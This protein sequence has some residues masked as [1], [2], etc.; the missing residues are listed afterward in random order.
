MASVRQGSQET[1]VPVPVQAGSAAALAGWARAFHPGVPEG[2]GR[3]GPLL[4][5]VRVCGTKGEPRGLGLLRDLVLS[6]LWGE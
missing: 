4:G 1:R 6:R 3:A 2:A 5:C